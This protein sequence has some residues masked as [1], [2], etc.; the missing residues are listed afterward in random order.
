LY[1]YRPTSE[2]EN[3]HGLS[4]A[5][6]IQRQRGNSFRKSSSGQ[7]KIASNPLTLCK[8]CCA[9]QNQQIQILENNVTELK[10]SL[11]I[12][13]ASQCNS[14]IHDLRKITQ[15]NK[16]LSALNSD[17][18]R[19][20]NDCETVTVNTNAKINQEW[21]AKLEQKENELDQCMYANAEHIHSTNRFRLKITMSDQVIQELNSTLQKSVLTTMNLTAEHNKC[22]QDC[23]LS[24]Q[25][26]NSNVSQSQTA[27]EKMDKMYQMCTAE[28]E[29]MLHNLSNTLQ[30]MNSIQVQHFEC[31]T[32]LDTVKKNS[33]DTIVSMKKQVESL[34][35]SL[36]ET[37][38]NWTDTNLQLTILTQEKDAFNILCLEKTRSIYDMS[39]KK[40][41]ECRHELDNVV[42]NSVKNVSL[43]FNQLSE[44][45]QKESL[46]SASMD[47]LN[48]QLVSAQQKL[49]KSTLQT[50]E[51]RN[52]LTNVVQ[53]S[54]KNISLCVSQLSD[55]MQNDSAKSV[56]IAELTTQLESSQ[57][58]LVEST[59]RIKSMQEL[60]AEQ[61][62]INR[63][64]IDNFN[65]SNRELLVAQTKVYAVDSELYTVKTR[66]KNTEQELYSTQSLYRQL[67]NVQ[68]FQEQK[69]L[70]FVKN[71]T[72]VKHRLK[73]LDQE[74]T[75]CLISMQNLAMSLENIRKNNSALE[76]TLNL[77]ILRL[78]TEHMRSK[79]CEN[80]L[81]I[82]EQYQNG[83]V[84]K[85]NSV[86]HENINLLQ[87]ITVHQNNYAALEKKLAFCELS[88]LNLSYEC[89][90]QKNYSAALIE[91]LR[92]QN[93]VLY[94]RI[95]NFE[96]E[97]QLKKN[98]HT[99]HN[100]SS[101][102]W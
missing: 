5:D 8:E 54:E 15:E 95:Q 45:M 90:T 93:N 49:L 35:T 60:Y 101:S 9:T 87:N 84:T 80:K 76:K 67:Q 41:T 58:K 24:M 13:M 69:L 94:V 99:L 25:I 55:V 78:E 3:D 34:S 19:L 66:L 59:L 18:N 52:E 68:H 7:K 77:E 50:T 56:S 61:N 17:C 21:R 89:E 31:R 40:V 27:F 53:N 2:N 96:T 57:Q 83:N 46:T 81:S 39:E 44:I 29:F 100:T 30:E 98:V 72:L 38:Q 73:I 11:D 23:D 74:V 92:V 97:S 28:H 14:Y 37:E 47:Q 1:T 32:E 102:N 82:L 62:E 86:T 22:R 71:E 64:C 20:K 36:A 10:K 26:C 4:L 70:E 33:S 6:I 88:K 63:V 75:S 42:Q 43:C 12:E 85:L 16:D 65:Q 79:S 48:S 51:C 91:L